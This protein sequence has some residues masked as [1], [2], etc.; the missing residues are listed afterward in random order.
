MPVQRAGAKNW[1]SGC[2]LLLSCCKFFLRPLSIGASPEAANADVCTIPVFETVASRFW[3]LAAF[4]WLLC[5][6]VL[7]DQPKWEHFSVHAVASLH[8]LLGDGL[9]GVLQDFHWSRPFTTVVMSFWFD[10]G[11]LNVRYFDSNAS[12][13]SSMK[14]DRSDNDRMSGDASGVLVSF[15]MS[16]S[17][18]WSDSTGN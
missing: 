2:Q 17:L 1:L 18:C 8:F 14:S 9:L 4:T 11:V 3:I 15:V 5:F 6:V 16:L 7:V 10:S 12:R 13:L